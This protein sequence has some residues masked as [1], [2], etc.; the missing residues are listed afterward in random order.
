MLISS[1]LAGATHTCALQGTE[2]HIHVY[3]RVQSHTHMCTAGYRGSHTCAGYRDS[4]PFDLKSLAYAQTLTFEKYK[5]TRL[6]II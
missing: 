1:D 6:N 5:K 4:C 3:C 2:P